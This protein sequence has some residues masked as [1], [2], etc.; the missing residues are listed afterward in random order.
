MDQERRLSVAVVPHCATY[1]CED[2]WSSS[3]VASIV[4]GCDLFAG[5][6]FQISGSDAMP[7]SPCLAGCAKYSLVSLS[8]G[9]LGVQFSH[10]ACCLH[11]PVVRA[12]RG[13]QYF[14]NVV[15]F[16]ATAAG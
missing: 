16:C 10:F 6:F 15:S 5:K 12:A 9:W 8:G 13:G 14:D 2:T 4:P 11:A 3:A 7:A 1:V